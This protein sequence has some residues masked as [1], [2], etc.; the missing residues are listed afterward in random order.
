M[1]VEQ[2][3]TGPSRVQGEQECLCHLDPRREQKQQQADPSP[4]FA[5]NATGFEMTNR[6]KDDRLKAVATGG[7]A[8]AARRFD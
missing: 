1:G 2:E 3:R 4:P 5:D 6:R 7:G 8:S